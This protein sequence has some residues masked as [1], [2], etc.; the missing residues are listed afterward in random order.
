MDFRKILSKGFGKSKHRIGGSSHKK[1]EASGNKTSTRDGRETP[2]VEGSE[3]SQRNSVDSEPGRGRGPDTIDGKTQMAEHVDPPTSESA[4]SHSDNGKPGGTIPHRFAFI[5]GTV[6]TPA[7]SVPVQEVPR[8]NKD[9]PSAADEKK[10]SRLSTAASAGKMFLV[11]VRESADAFGPLKTIAG[12]LCFIVDNFE[13]PMPSPT[14]TIH[15][16]YKV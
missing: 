1:R 10:A 12:C 2:D 14:P 6:D 7:I 5:S 9:E 11:G 15:D 13:V 3:G 4:I 8:P 16:T